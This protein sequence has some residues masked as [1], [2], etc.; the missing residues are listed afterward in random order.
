META[1]RHCCD[2]A[3]P[4]K[5]ADLSAKVGDLTGG[6]GV[7]AVIITAGTSSLDPINCAGELARKRGRVV[8]VGAVPTG[9]DREPNWYK[10]ELELRMS[11]SY[12]PG[13]YDMEY[14]E[15][16]VDY[17]P[18]YV[19]WTENRNMAAFQELV[20]SDK[21]D[22]SYLTSHEFA[23]E[24]ASEAY[25]MIVN[26]ARRRIEL[27]AVE[28]QG[29]V[30]IAFVG[31]GSYAQQNLLPNIPLNDKDITCVGIMDSSG[32]TS[33]RVAE[34]F[35]F[36][37][38]TS[39]P[40]DIFENDTVNTVFIATR[41]DS[42]AEYVKSAFA[43]G[44]HVFVEK[45]LCLYEEELTEIKELYHGADHGCRLMLGFNRRFAPHAV[46]LKKHLDDTP[47]SMLYRI[48]A[49]SIPKGSWIQDDEIGG[50]RIIGEVCHF[51]DFLSWLCGSLPRH[52]HAVAIP[53][54]DGLNDTVSINLQFDNGSVGAISY[55]A[56]GS[57]ELPKEYIEVF[58]SG[59][60]GIIQDFKEMRIYGKG[61]PSRNR[62]LNQD[63]GQVEMMR[64]FIELLKR[65]GSPLISP[66]EIFT[67]TEACFAV[68]K[69]LKTRQSVTVGQ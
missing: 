55:F 6:L 61:K 43:A 21:V 5:S 16:G 30:N 26:R 31:A 49:G 65:G 19:R 17:P 56:N 33:K 52:V 35:N 69:S 3:W 54:G 20:Y 14:E 53:D 59:L 8:V 15:K 13:R 22:V 1:S 28:A 2:H 9:F 25:D 12:G 57:K 44:K 63:K 40:A 66:D 11:C 41:H 48:N 68:L 18:A 47:V 10:K 24:R 29:K 23:L 45:P 34:K 38:C 46:E 67:V 64:Q 39:E 7:D 58:S 4:R 37:F 36:E 27:R 50:G 62:L 42:H 51:I 60:T 32:T